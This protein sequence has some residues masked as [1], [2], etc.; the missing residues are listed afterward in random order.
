MARMSIDDKV[1]RDPRI[2]ILAGLLGWS[3]RETIGCLVLDVWPIC[4]D[5]GTHL[6]SE[7]VIDAAAGHPGFAQKLIESE[8]ATLDR[9]GKIQIGG[10]KERIAYL[11]HKKASGRQGGIKSAESR[12][13][14]TKQTSSTRG[15]TPQARGNPSVPDPA[16]ANTP[17]TQQAAIA[18]FHSYYLGT[19]GG[20]K[21]TWGDK[22]IGMMSG[23]VKS[24]GADEVIRRVSVLRDSPPTFPAPPWDLGTFVG[25]FD[26]VSQPTKAAPRQGELP[27]TNLPQ[28]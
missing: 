24:H 18:A 15:S 6:V 11:D 3:R 16:A 1:G 4:Y 19:H 9:S 13:K 20:S 22:Q 12:A 2:T 7:R 27:R 25:N 21:P 23:L 8:L 28:I 14:D 10:A 17:A 26:K 5:Q